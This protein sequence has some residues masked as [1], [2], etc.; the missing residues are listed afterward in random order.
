M[1]GGLLGMSSNINEHRRLLQK[2][3]KEIDPQVIVAVDPTQ[4]FLNQKLKVTILKGKNKRELE[5]TE[6]DL[7]EALK[8]P[9][10]LKARLGEVLKTLS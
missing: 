2:L 10:P 4:F 5:V 7:D 1:A 3:A 9:E 6:S 8:V